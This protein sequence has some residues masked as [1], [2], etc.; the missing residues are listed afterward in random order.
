MNAVSGKAVVLVLL[1]IL[2]VPALIAILAIALAVSGIDYR[3][4]D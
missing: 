1:A 3:F 4:A 2:S